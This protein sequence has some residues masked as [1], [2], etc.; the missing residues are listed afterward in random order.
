MS[1]K[2]KRVPVSGQEKAELLVLIRDHYKA[3][4]TVWG[5]VFWQQIQ[6]TGNVRI[7]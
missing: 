2:Q 5:N 3:N 6:G 1:D 7:C 4:K